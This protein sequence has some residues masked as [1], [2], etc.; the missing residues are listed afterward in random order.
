MSTNIDLSGKWRMEGRQAHVPRS[1]WEAELVLYKT[2]NL[3]W[4]VTK[5]NNIGASR[6]GKWNV[7]GRKFT[8]N[9]HAPIVGLVEWQGEL[10]GTERM[11]GTYRTP[12][13]GPQPIGW[14]GYWGAVKLKK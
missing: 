11:G 1:D 14:G 3:Y 7:D 2:G 8:M 13:A 5:G 10:S 9:Y 4:K 12:Q 6:R